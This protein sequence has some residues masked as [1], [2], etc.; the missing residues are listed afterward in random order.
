MEV[1]EVRRQKDVFLLLQRLRI[2]GLLGDIAFE[3]DFGFQRKHF[4]LAEI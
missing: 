3:F 1:V 4:S 2:F